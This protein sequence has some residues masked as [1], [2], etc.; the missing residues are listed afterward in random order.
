MS[1]K[2]DKFCDGLRERLTAI[3]GRV[4]T[5]RTAVQGLPAKAEKALQAK[6]QEARTKMQSQKERVQNARADFESWVEL[7]RTETKEAINEWKVK[8]EA[9]KLDARAERAEAYAEAAMFLA[10]NSIDEAEAAV[11][12]AV[13]ARLDAD[14]AK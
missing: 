11:L 8:R 5:V 12:D 6:L 3:E 7:K 13:A 9:R 2:V 1:E 4:Q 10:L 14:E